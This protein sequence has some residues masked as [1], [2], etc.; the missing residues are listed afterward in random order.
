MQFAEGSSGSTFPLSHDSRVVNV[1][2]GGQFQKSW[3]EHVDEGLG[4]P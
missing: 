2:H 4:P 3:R 1:E